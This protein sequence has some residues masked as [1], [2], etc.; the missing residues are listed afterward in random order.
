[1]GDFKAKI[2]GQNKGYEAVMGKHGLEIMN[3][4]GELFAETHVNNNLETG[5]GVFPHKTTHKTTW[6]SPDHV[7]E[8]QIAHICISK[9]FRRAME[10]VKSKKRGRYSVRLPSPDR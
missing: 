5:G 3:E 2:G 6:L 10:D 4:N 1:M 8:N 7:T 9:K